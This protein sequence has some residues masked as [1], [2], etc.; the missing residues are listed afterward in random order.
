MA[1]VT[2][3]MPLLYYVEGGSTNYSMGIP[4]YACFVMA[5][6]YVLL[7]GYKVI[8]NWRK[9]VSGQQKVNL[10]TIV[11]LI[12]AVSILQ[13][14]IPELL[15]TSIVAALVS[16]SAY[17]NQ[18]DPLRQQSLA[19]MQSLMDEVAELNEKLR[20]QR[21]KYTDVDNTGVWLEFVG[22]RQETFRVKYEDFYLA[23]SEGNYVSIQYY[24]GGE[25]HKKVLRQTMKAILETV[26]KYPKIKRVHRAYIVN[27]DHQITVEGS[28]SQG[29]QL[30]FEGI[31][32]PIPVSRNLVAELQELISE[33]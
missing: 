15:I 4:V 14:N 31:R 25:I 3:T 30:I 2:A 33:G 24:K 6:F 23:E 27:L 29:F 5:Y 32:E 10:V 8:L 16:V 17:I 18:E 13:F 28:S 20:I 26:E 22:S 11:F 7:L 9:I 12:A 19:N 21:E 1:V